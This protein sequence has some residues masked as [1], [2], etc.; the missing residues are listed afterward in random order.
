MINRTCSEC[1]SLSKVTEVEKCTD[2]NKESLRDTTSY[3]ADDVALYSVV[4]AS[5]NLL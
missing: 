5:S 4:I 2:G 1:R 3:N